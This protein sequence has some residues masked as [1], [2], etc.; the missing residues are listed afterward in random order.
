MPAFMLRQ[1]IHFAPGATPISLLP[2]ETWPT[3][4]PTVCVPWPLS[5]QGAVVFAP[6]ELP[7]AWT[8]SCQ[9]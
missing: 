3:A 4:V 5:S 6:Q 1:P 7:P 2:A 8:L 9:L